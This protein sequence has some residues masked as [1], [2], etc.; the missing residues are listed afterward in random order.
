MSDVATALAKAD[1]DVAA[2]YSRLAGE[3][4]EKFFPAIRREYKSCVDLVLRL[5]RQNELLEASRTLRRAIRLRNPYVD[6]MSFLQ[7]DMLE[8]WRADGR[9]DGAGAAG[10]D[11]EHQRHRSRDAGNRLSDGQR[12]GRRSGA[13]LTQR[14]MRVSSSSARDV[15][16]RERAAAHRDS[17][18]MH[19]RGIARDERMPPVERLTGRELAVSARRRQPIE[20]ARVAG[21]RARRNRVRAGDAAVT[22][23]AAAVA[24]EQLAGDVGV[25]DL[26]RRFVLKLLQAAAPAAVAERF[27]LLRCQ[28][29]ELLALPKRLQ[30]VTRSEFDLRDH[31]KLLAMR[32]KPK[33]VFLDFAARLN[34]DYWR[35][36]AAADELD[37]VLAAGGRLEVVRDEHERRARGLV[38]IEQQVEDLRAGLVV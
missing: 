5:T 7:V 15:V 16:L 23:A 27:P 12:A 1:L 21:P 18:A 17:G 2:R 22:R 32:A 38:Q 6:P 28:L 33:A 26:A 24:I 8:R 11:G 29:R 9:Q 31:C 20:R 3:R 30:C 35:Y 34:V 14:M 36:D 19:R 4:H 10:A 25:R 13:V 37:D